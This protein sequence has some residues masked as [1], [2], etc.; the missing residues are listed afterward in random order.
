MDSK[1]RNPA[2]TVK[3][4]IYLFIYLFIWTHKKTSVLFTLV[5][6]NKNANCSRQFDGEKN[7]R[8]SIYKTA[9]YLHSNLK[10]GPSFNGDSRTDCIAV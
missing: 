5:R 8:Y 2:Q 7:T 4:N 9:H 1:Y 6:L 3:T 10:Q